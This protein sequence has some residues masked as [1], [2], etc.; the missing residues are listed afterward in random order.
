MQVED[1]LTLSAYNIQKES[2]LHLILRLRGGMYLEESSRMGFDHLKLASR[3]IFELLLPYH[4][5]G[6]TILR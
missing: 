3:N 2:T 4:P 6:K 5:D 1:G